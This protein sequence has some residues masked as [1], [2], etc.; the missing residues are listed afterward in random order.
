MSLELMKLSFMFDNLPSPCIGKHI[1]NSTLK[2]ILLNIKNTLPTYKPT[3][4]KPSKSNK[5]SQSWIGTR[6]EVELPVSKEEHLRKTIV[7]EIINQRFMWVDDYFHY[8][9]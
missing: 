2:Q 6:Q 8:A 5:I 4:S 7:P 1:H 9:D 3:I